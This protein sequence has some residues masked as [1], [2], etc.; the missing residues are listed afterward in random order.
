MTQHA[1]LS[2]ERWAAL[3]HDRRILSI[4]NEM[5][6]AGKLTRADDT[7]RRR[8]AYAR[9]LQLA[10]LTAE[11]SDRRAVRRELLRWREC[12]A[13]LYLAEGPEPEAHRASFGVLLLMSREAARQR[14]YVLHPS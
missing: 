14:P 7:E 2:K 9:V 4:A 3:G 13:L 11:V 8:N 12:V 1:G 5:N 6:R 10:D